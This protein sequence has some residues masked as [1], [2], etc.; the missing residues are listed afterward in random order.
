MAQLNP[1]GHDLHLEMK[2]VIERGIFALNS[3]KEQIMEKNLN[4]YDITIW[5]VHSLVCELN[6]AKPVY[7][8]IAAINKQIN[9]YQSGIDEYC[10]NSMNECKFSG[11]VGNEE[12]LD[13]TEAKGDENKNDMDMAKLEEEPELEAKRLTVNSRVQGLTN[14]ENINV[15]VNTRGNDNGND[16]DNGAGNDG[17]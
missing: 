16:L 11:A 9:H 15:A 7:V 8:L 3:T 2:Q 17:N 6:E 13:F 14:N 12:K 4:A 1:Y 10:G 5:V